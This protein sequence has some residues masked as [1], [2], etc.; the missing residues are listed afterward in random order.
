MRHRVWYGVTLALLSLGLVGTAIGYPLS[1][2][3]E[4]ALVGDTYHG[5]DGGRPGEVAVE[6]AGTYAIWESGKT[7]PDRSRCRVTRSDG[8]AVPVTA[9]RLMV[10][11]YPAL[12]GDAIGVWT[13]VA[14]FDAPRADRYTISCTVDPDS[15]GH[16][17]EVTD[18]P[19]VT[20]T[21]AST[22]GGVGALV[23]AA[24]IG[25]TTFVRRRRRQGA[26]TV[27]SGSSPS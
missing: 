18:R 21:L 19:N 25:V 3:P 2:S 13:E 26:V 16:S 4:P 10:Y 15:P 14:T 24:A 27:G 11:W 20:L 6:R 9:P 7:H 5:L 8:S 12:S 23:A 22:I 1:P 17:F